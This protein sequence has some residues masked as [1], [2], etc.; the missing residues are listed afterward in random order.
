MIFHSYSLNLIQEREGLKSRIFFHVDKFV[1][2][3]LCKKSLM[4][5]DGAER[6]PFLW[7]VVRKTKLYR[8]ILLHLTIHLSDFLN[9]VW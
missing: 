4:L 1:V 7:L 5:S 9:D 8:S 6:E 3:L 2:V